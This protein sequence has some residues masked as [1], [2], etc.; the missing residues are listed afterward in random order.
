MSFDVI[1]YNGAG[2]FA[3]R[4]EVPDGWEGPAFGPRDVALGR[5]ESAL[6]ELARGQW[7]E[8]PS[9][10]PWR[11]M[12]TADGFSVDFILPATVPGQIKLSF[13]GDLDRALPTLR[14]LHAEPSWGVVTQETAALNA[15]DALETS[16][17]AWQA[18]RSRAA[19]RP[20]GSPSLLQR[21]RS[22]FHR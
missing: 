4:S 7:S 19:S 14:A 8:M 10:G 5:I 12:L 18:R 20:S 9:D 22:A 21:I 1:L 2:A 3:S 13:R 11:V 16:V 6:P 17:S 15:A